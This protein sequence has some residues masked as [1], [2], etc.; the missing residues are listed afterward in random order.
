M[1]MSINRLFPIRAV[2]PGIC[3]VGRDKFTAV[4][5]AVPINFALRSVRDQ[6]RLV[7]GYTAFLNGLSFPVELLVRADLLRLDEYLG[8]L[9]ANEEEIAPHLRPSLGDYIEF[10][11]ATV[12]VQHLLR[13]RFY[14]VL[15]WQG[16]DSRTRPARRGEVL[17][18]EAEQEL[19]RRRDIVSQGLRPLGIRLKTLDA[20]ETFRFLYAGLGAG[21]PLP[22]GVNWAWD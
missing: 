22:P 19:E 1:A 13:R 2:G 4:L 16:V 10:I 9:K 17:W 21:E 18:E 7:N 11:R 5:E 12:S 15:S 14:L 3:L 6:E 8:Q 20:E